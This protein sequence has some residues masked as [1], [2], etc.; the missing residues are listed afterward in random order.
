MNMMINVEFAN[1]ITN[2][3]S[4]DFINSILKNGTKDIQG[5]DLSILRK[6]YSNYIKSIKTYKNNNHTRITTLNDTIQQMPKDIRSLENEIYYKQKV[7]K[8]YKFIKDLKD[9]YTTNTAE[10]IIKAFTELRDYDIYN[11]YDL[12]FIIS[13]FDV[14]FTIDFVNDLTKYFDIEIFNKKSTIYT[15][16]T[17]NQFIKLVFNMFLGIDGNNMFEIISD[18]ISMNYDIGFDDY[19]DDEYINDVKNWD[20]EKE[21]ILKALNDIGLTEFSSF[22]EINV[23]QFINNAY[24]RGRWNN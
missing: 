12:L 23:D 17:L 3:Y 14:D 15:W 21:N 13:L 5:E 7:L 19:L 4:K 22:L 9:K 11:K 1:M 18:N 6:L 10:N 24:R 8:E 16:E 2:K 20:N